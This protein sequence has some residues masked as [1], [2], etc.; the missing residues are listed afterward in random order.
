LIGVS[1]LQLCEACC[2]E[3]IIKI[4]KRKI[5]VSPS[6]ACRYPSNWTNFF[7]FSKKENNNKQKIMQRKK[8]K[9]NKKK[10][11]KKN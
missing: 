9:E 3:K 6:L 10:K 11:K 5:H 8:K 1:A 4:I 7:S 2:T